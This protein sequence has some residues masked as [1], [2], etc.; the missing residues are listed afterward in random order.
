VESSMYFNV[1]GIFKCFPT[2]LTYI[3]GLPSMNNFVF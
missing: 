3:R 1:T 2:A